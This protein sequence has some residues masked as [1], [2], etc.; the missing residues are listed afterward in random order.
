MDA[1]TRR[2]LRHQITVG[3]HPLQGQVQQAELGDD[4]DTDLDDLDDLEDLEDLDDVD[5]DVLVAMLVMF[6]RC[7]VKVKEDGLLGKFTYFYG[8]WS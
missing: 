2:H 3:G 5:L 6:R 1:I 8:P 7:V 4:G